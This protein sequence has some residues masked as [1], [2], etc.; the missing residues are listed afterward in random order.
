MKKII[1][2][3]RAIKELFK[4]FLLDPASTKSI[5]FL[6]GECAACGGMVAIGLSQVDAFRGLMAE[7]VPCP[8]CGVKV[9]AITLFKKYGLSDDVEKDLSDIVDVAFHKGIIKDI[10]YGFGSAGSNN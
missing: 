4:A 5:L 2:K 1:K 8:G 10:D 9:K 3:V 7:G 6:T